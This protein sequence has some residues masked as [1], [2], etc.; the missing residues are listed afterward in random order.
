MFSS[1][2]PGSLAPNRLAAAVADARRSGRAL[3]DLTTSNPTRAGIP[4]PRDLLDGL[5]APEGLVYRPEPLGL[6]SARAAV[7]ADYARRGMTVD[8]SRVVLT[9]STS[10]AYSLLFKLLCDPGDEVLVP[11]PSYPLFEHLTRLDAIGG[12]P[13]A[14]EYH[15]VWS[16]DRESVERAIT[17]RTRALLVVAPNN[18]TGSMLRRDDREWL[19]V[20]CAEWGLAVIADEVF[21]DYPLEPADDAAAGWLPARDGAVPP[22]ALAFSVGGLSKTVGLP[23]V[24]LGWMAVAGPEPAAS[25]ALARL[26]LVCDT[27]LS[28][29]TPAQLALPVLLQRC[30]ALRAAIGA[31]LASNLRDLR[32]IVSRTPACEVLRVEGGW[33]AV[34]RVP[35]IVPEETLALD[36]LREDGVLAHPGFFFDFPREAY[37]VV[38]LLPP[39]PEFTAAVERLCRRAGGGA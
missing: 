15:G 12:V 38:S 30:A 10:E 2:V 4:Y 23:Q 17:D 33:T 29:S 24:K 32:H 19:D 37:L 18:P 34:V 26:E 3:L 27:Y 6:E 8:P 25:A 28:V 20:R 31:R 7:S 36:L 14:L 39:P 13:Y 22:R 35:A 21:A 16:V 1:R 11:R 9:S 5:A